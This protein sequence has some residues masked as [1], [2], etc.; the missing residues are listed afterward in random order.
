[1]DVTHRKYYSIGGTMVAMREWVNQGS[2]TTYYLAS[3]HLSSTS[4][5]VD[6]SG[7]LLSENVENAQHS[8]RQFGKAKWEK[9]GWSTISKNYG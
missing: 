8:P 3:D 2:A 1:V 5:V 4:I 9:Y 6:S 7:G